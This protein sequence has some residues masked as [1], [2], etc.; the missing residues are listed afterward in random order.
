MKRIF[1]EVDAEN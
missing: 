1:G